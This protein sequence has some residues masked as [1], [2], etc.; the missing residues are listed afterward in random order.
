MN[1]HREGKGSPCAFG[2]H[3]ERGERSAELLNWE[4][5]MGDQ[6][7]RKQQSVFCHTERC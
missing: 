2:E 7:D 5:Q 4:L 6:Q 3:Q 1:I